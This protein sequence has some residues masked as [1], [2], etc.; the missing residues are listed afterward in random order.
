MSQKFPGR[1]CSRSWSSSYG[2][3]DTG[4]ACM[5]VEGD[6]RWDGKGRGLKGS[7]FNERDP[8]PLSATSIILPLTSTSPHHWDPPTARIRL[9]LPPAAAASSRQLACLFLFASLLPLIKLPDTPPS[10]VWIW[11]CVSGSC[12][13]RTCWIYSHTCILFII[14]KGSKWVGLDRPGVFSWRWQPMGG[15]EE[16]DSELV[17]DGR[18]WRDGLWTSVSFSSSSRDSHTAGIASRCLCHSEVETGFWMSLSFSIV[19]LWKSIIYF[20]VVKSQ[21]ATTCDLCSVTLLDLKHFL[22]VIYEKGL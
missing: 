22:K 7:D 21:L 3:R 6:G 2:R 12:Y 8:T 20:I 9:A 4:A 1:W 11:T 14:R 5:V 10:H 17:S 15:L 16:M 18:P 13:H 19:D